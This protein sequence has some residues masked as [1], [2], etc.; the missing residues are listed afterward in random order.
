MKPLQ[1]RA[2]S[3]G[4]RGSDNLLM[5]GTG[6]VT[7][8]CRGLRDPE[9]PIALED[10][11]VM[12]VEIEGQAL[13]RIEVDGTVERIAALDGGPNGAAL[14]PQNRVYICNSGGW[15]YRDI[16]DSRGKMF[17]SSSGQNPRL[18]WIE[19]VDPRS[20]RSE[21]L[22]THC[23][24][25]P[26]QS[27]NDLVFDAGGH[28]YFTDYGKRSATALSIGAVY[29]AASD[30]SHIVK[31]IDGLV[32]PNG[33]GL[34]PDGRTLY[35]A[36]TLTRRLW[37]FDLETPERIIRQ[38]WPSPCGGRLLASLPDYNGLD[39]LAVDV[40]G[41]I[42]VASLVN[43][44]I[45]SIAPD[46][47]ARSHLEIDDPFTS[48]VCFGGLGM[49]TLFVTMSGSGAL[50]R[51]KWPVAGLPLHFSSRHNPPDALRED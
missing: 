2:N 1:G 30:G 37:A 35:V 4:R 13:T 7:I 23:N 9:G 19:C 39:S 49:K 34:S 18:G 42:H 28:F 6:D 27:P 32:T 10:G 47:S 31:V 29:R 33:I 48:N 14:G 11:S 17:H 15:L 3:A 25:E 24:G 46:G 20:G 45:W 51:L 40:Q 5:T 26:L 44:G 21:R 36:E 22:Y 12:V 8:I 43:G 38:P 41:W 16:T 50:G